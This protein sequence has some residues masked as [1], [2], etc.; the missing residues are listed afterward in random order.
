MRKFLLHRI[1]LVGLGIFCCLNVL[2]AKEQT[3]FGRLIGYGKSQK[4]KEAHEPER[5]KAI[6][7]HEVSRRDLAGGVGVLPP[8]NSREGQGKNEQV[9]NPDR[10]RKRVVGDEVEGESKPKKAKLISKEKKPLTED[11]ADRLAKEK[12]LDN[13]DRKKLE[14]TRALADK[15]SPL[16]ERVQALFSNKPEL[17]PIVAQNTYLSGKEKDL[18]VAATLKGGADMH[19]ILTGNIE[20]LPKLSDKPTKEEKQAYKESLHDMSWFLFNAAAKKDTGTGNKGMASGMILLDGPGAEYFHKYV[21]NYV[22]A[23]S[24]YPSGKLI[25]LD[26]SGSGAYE[27]ESSHFNNCRKTSYGIDLDTPVITQ[28]DGKGKPN[29]KS[30]LHVGQMEDGRVFVKFEQYG[31][32]KEEFLA[33]AGGFVTKDLIP[34]LRAK[35]KGADEQKEKSIQ[36]LLNTGEIKHPEHN[37]I[38]N[39][40]LEIAA[41]THPI[42]EPEVRKAS[43]LQRGEKWPKGYNPL[44][45][46]ML[47]EK[48]VPQNEIKDIMKEVKTYGFQAMHKHGQEKGLE[49][50]DKDGNKHNFVEVLEKKYGPDV[51]NRF[52]NEV[53]LTDKDLKKDAKNYHNALSQE[54]PAKEIVAA[55][56]LGSPSS[57][58]SELGT[59]KR[60]DAVSQI[61]RPVHAQEVIPAP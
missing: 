49:I 43:S 34:K 32:G 20:S 40:E 41:K 9:S 25:G 61:E 19:K 57:V 12:K 35:F 54:S 18:A 23:V 15:R 42:G 55:P 1:V 28:P 24:P 26:K 36:Q 2:S 60:Q 8:V 51:K 44:F 7:R 6:E 3:T 39:Q 31:L 29:Y 50:T 58:S 53:V 17:K 10:K 16:I 46:S 5:E 48:G 38:A 37:T 59:L 27:R 45:E 33:H 47:H 21:E 13:I 4:S 14:R 30:H 11:E 52:F 56:V 22:K